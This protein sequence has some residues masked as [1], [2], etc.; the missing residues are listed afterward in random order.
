MG[1]VNKALDGFVEWVDAKSECVM[2]AEI[3]ARKELLSQSDQMKL[4]KVELTSVREHFVIFSKQLLA[5]K[6][7][8]Q[9]ILRQ[10]ND[11]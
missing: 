3:N 6:K 11:T 1:L 5:D 4:L 10:S 2:E 9:D 8:Q 7:V